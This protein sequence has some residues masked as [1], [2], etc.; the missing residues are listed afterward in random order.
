M[1]KFTDRNLITSLQDYHLIMFAG[2]TMLKSRAMYDMD[3]PGI[4]RALKDQHLN[5]PGLIAGRVLQAT[6]RYRDLHV[7]SVA[8]VRLEA[9]YVVAPMFYRRHRHDP[10]DVA[11]VAEMC[12]T[13]YR[14]SLLYLVSVGS[15]MKIAIELPE[16]QSIILNN[17]LLTLPNNFG[18]FKNE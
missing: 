11:L 8:G 10:V 17:I 16:D 5:L 13:L 1:A 12:A 3:T 14:E 18:I 15:E 4:A 7:L 6:E 2:H 9:G